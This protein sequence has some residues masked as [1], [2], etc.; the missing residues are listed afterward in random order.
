[1]RTPLRAAARLASDSLFREAPLP[2]VGSDAWRFLWEAART[3]SDEVAYPGRIFPAPVEDERCVLCQQP[4]EDDA[5]GRQR[6]FETFVKGAAQKATADAARELEE[7]RRNLTG[8]RMP[9]GKIRALVTFLKT[10]LDRPGM[11]SDVWRSALTAAWRLRA[12]LAGEA[13]PVGAGA[14]S[15]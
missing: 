8:A 7:Y 3:Y 13:E 5:R 11:A 1:M 6:A 9:V 12:L 2:G 15:G 10:E 4:L 14:G